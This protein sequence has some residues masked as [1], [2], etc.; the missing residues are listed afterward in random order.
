[1]VE[2][3]GGDLRGYEIKWADKKVKTPTS[4]VNGYKNAKFQ[5]ISKSN[6]LEFIT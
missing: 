4:W 5:V 3:S 6:Y 1:M 2:E